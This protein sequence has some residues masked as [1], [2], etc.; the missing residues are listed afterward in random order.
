MPSKGVNP[1]TKSP[2]TDEALTVASSYRRCSK[3]CLKAN[4]FDKAVTLAKR[5]RDID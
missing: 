1:I 4:M 2:S 3:Y 5:E